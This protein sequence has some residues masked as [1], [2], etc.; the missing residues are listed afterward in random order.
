MD[1]RPKYKMQNYKTPRIQE[2]NL[3]ELGYSNEI[4]DTILKAK[5]MKETTDQLN[6][7][8]IKNFCSLKDTID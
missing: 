6:F 7:I 8:K 4:L 5:S 1:H 2:K 3:D